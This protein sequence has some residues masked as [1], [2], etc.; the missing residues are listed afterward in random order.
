[1]NLIY[2]FLLF[3]TSVPRTCGAARSVTSPD[4]DG[5]ASPA[6]A[7]AGPCDRPV[8]A[9]SAHRH[10]SAAAAGA[11]GLGRVRSEPGCA[12]RVGLRQALMRLAAIVTTRRN[13]I[14]PGGQPAE[15][16]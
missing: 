2:Y 6:L 3:D 8:H 13:T 16:A 14:T 10:M 7:S 1:M 4:A 12:F 15:G 11:F 9:L 5:Y